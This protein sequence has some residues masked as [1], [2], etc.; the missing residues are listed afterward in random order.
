MNQKGVTLIELVVVF[1]IIAI[2][3]A[4]TVPGIGAWLPQYRLRSATRDLVSTMRV[5]QI[6]AISKNLRY[7]ISFDIPNRT[8]IVQYQNTGN[9]FNDGA[10]QILPAGVQFNTNFGNVANF[11]PNSSSTDGNVT[12]NNTKGTAKRIQLLG[13][14]GRIKIE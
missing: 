6:K 1:V 14:T 2:G 3:A 12:L 11:F 13:T 9:T 7:Q 10:V 4:L 5:A 8:Y